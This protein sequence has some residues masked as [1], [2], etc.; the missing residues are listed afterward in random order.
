[1]R[2]CAKM[3]DKK[4]LI[5]FLMVRLWFAQVNRNFMSS[6]GYHH[7]TTIFGLIFVQKMQMYCVDI[8]L[9][10]AALQHVTP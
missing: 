9:C 8:L 7:I 3:P 4:C 1:M 10:F 6:T 5:I 2:C